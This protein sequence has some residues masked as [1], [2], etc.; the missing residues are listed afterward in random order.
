MI[1]LVVA[2]GIVIIFS[3]PTQTKLPLL[4]EPVFKKVNTPQGTKTDT[5]YPVIPRFNF[6]DQLKQPVSNQTYK[7]HIYV[8]DFFFTS[9]PTICPVMSRNLKKVYDQY[10][11]FP[12]L[13]FL[14]YTIDPKYDTPEVLNRYAK[15]LGADAKRWHFVTGP[16]EEI[17]QLAEKGYY[18]PANKDDSV[19]GGYVHSGGLILIDRNGHMRGVYDGT[20]DEEVGWL[21]RDLKILL[22]EK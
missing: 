4:G 16:K 13:M 3:K 19:D 8:A 11:A 1:C 14:S 12:E 6:T 10:A 15:A 17:Y 2:V 21:I 9:C 22:A 20:S 18:S 7:G 5:I